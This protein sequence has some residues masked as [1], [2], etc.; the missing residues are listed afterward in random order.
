[1]QQSEMINYF[2]DLWVCIQPLPLTFLSY[3]EVVPVLPASY[4]ALW[5]SRVNAEDERVTPSRRVKKENTKDVNKVK[6]LSLDSPLTF[7][8]C[9][10]NFE[11]LLQKN[12]LRQVEGPL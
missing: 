8:W 7:T 11:D 3:V 4:T 12:F 5:W 9:E 10:F 1:M 6:H 2:G